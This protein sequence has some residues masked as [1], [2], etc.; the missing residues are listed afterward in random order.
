[1]V[2]IIPS[3][4]TSKSLPRYPTV[5]GMLTE[6]SIP[7]HVS[8]SV[9]CALACSG[10]SWDAQG[11]YLVPLDPVATSQD[12]EPSWPLCCQRGAV[13][14]LVAMVRFGIW[15]FFPTWQ[16]ASAVLKPG[17]RP[18]AWQQLQVSLALRAVSQQNWK[19]LQCCTE[20][21]GLL[22]PSPKKL[23]WSVPAGPP[24][25][26]SHRARKRGLLSG[27][28]ARHSSTGTSHWGNDCNTHSAAEAWTEGNNL[29]QAQPSTATGK[30]R[31]LTGLTCTA[32]VRGGALKNTQLYYS[33]HIFLHLIP[34]WASRQPD[35]CPASLR[36]QGKAGWAPRP[37]SPQAGT[38][39]RPSSPPSHALPRVLRELLSRHSWRIHGKA[40]RPLI[41]PKI[42][43]LNIASPEW[44]VFWRE[45][46]SE[47][48]KTSV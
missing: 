38:T 42:P 11:T 47:R 1:M 9:I 43:G 18:L 31:G 46:T 41:C 17:Q 25:P 48:A 13:G 8:S 3:P 23:V 27:R 28:A 34:T 30:S 29:R 39:R 2:W 37:G 45:T 21:T 7:R 6:G 16:T 36:Q 19:W 20:K 14:L 4:P 10:E 12:R 26:H 24:P 32:V 15:G 44:H 40:K 33:H 5:I 35:A 22:L